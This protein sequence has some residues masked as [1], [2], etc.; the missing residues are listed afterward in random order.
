MTKLFFL[1]FSCALARFGACAP[2]H[3]ENFPRISA[4]HYLKY[5]LYLRSEEYQKAMTE[6]ILSHQ[7]NL[8]AMELVEEIVGLSLELQQAAIAQ[9]YVQ[10]A[11]QLS[12]NHPKSFLL[13]AQVLAAIGKTKEALGPL[14]AAY[15]MEPKNPDILMALVSNYALLND[16]KNALK[17]LE[18]YIAVSEPGTELLKIKAYYEFE[19]NSPKSIMT[20]TKAFEEDPEDPELLDGLAN[21][22]LKFSGQKSLEQFLKKSLEANP[23]NSHLRLKLCSVMSEKQDKRACLMETLESE[24]LNTQ[25]L[26]LLLEDFEKAEEWEEALITLRDHPNAALHDPVFVLK[27]S[28]YLLQSN[29]IVAAVA[30]LEKHKGR[31]P[32]NDDIPY[33]L[34]LGYQDMGEYDKA[35]NELSR[36][37]QRRP[38]WQEMAYSYALV[39]GELQDYSC[40]EKVLEELWRAHPDNPA[41]A[42]ALGYTWAE[43][44]KNLKEAQKLIE[45]ALTADPKNPSYIDSLAWALFKQGK[46]PQALELLQGVAQESHDPEITLHLGRLQKSLGKIEEAWQSY[47]TAKFD[48]AAGKKPSSRLKADL[49][50]LERSLDKKAK[51]EPAE[52]LGRQSAS[53]QNGFAGIFR[54]EWKVP[55]LGSMRVR[56]SLRFSQEED[57]INILYW[58]PGALTPVTGRE[59]ALSLPESSDILEE[60]ETALEDFFA[61][62]TWARRNK[63]HWDTAKIKQGRPLKWKVKNDYSIRAKG[64]RIRLEFLDFYRETAL[65]SQSEIKGGALVPRT[66]KLNSRPVHATCEALDYTKE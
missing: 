29:D 26:G 58:P 48:L 44:N 7:A 30:A 13:E 16:K 45:Q 63:S 19:E 15:G 14:L 37:Y 27:E 8:Q 62:Q 61:G 24:P 47:F 31:F 38:D 55:S 5:L 22:Y 9:A 42:N 46:Q 56:L 18:A 54:C 32:E 53:M 65:K 33:F 35:K 1:F 10:I 6:L 66:I 60:F 49:A 28:Y 52:V 25:A 4:H 51:P 64:R 59:V 12:P 43:Q 50:E 21:A 36:L 40:M 20:Y 11:K 34:A 3:A 41:F 17:Y 23:E 2:L 57:R 39:C